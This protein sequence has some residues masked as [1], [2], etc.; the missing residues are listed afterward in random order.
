[1]D[2]YFIFEKR[3]MFQGAY[4]FNQDIGR[5][6]VSR[7]K[8]FVSTTAKNVNIIMNKLSQLFCQVTHDLLQ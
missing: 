1:M 7:G 8:D 3:A 5:W 6:D 2:Y 4:A